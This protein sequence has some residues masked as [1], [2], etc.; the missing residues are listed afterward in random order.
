METCMARADRAHR[1]AAIIPRRFFWSQGWDR[2]GGRRG[3][4]TSLT[5]EAIL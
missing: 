1:K 5:G 3:D 2:L 4:E